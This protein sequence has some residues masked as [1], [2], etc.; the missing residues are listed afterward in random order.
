MVIAGALSL[1]VGPGAGAAVAPGQGTS[2][3]Q[4]LQVTPHE[5]SLAVGVVLGE[6]LAG[7]TN[8]VARAQSQGIDL[9]AIGTSLTGFNCGQSPAVQPSQIPQP[10]QTETGQQ[11]ADQGLTQTPT[12]PGPDLT[13]KNPPPAFGS[14]EF[15]KA[16]A[17]PYGEA[18]TSFAPIDSPV[19]SV[20]GLKTKSW[21]GLIGGQREAGATS[22]VGALSLLGGLVELKGLHWES[23]YPSGG[24]AQP[25]ASFSIGQ[26]LVKGV[27]V[28]V[29]GGPAAVVSAVNKVLGNLGMELVLP[30]K[31]ASS[32]VVSES[33]LQLLVV[34]NDA[35]DNVVNQL[36]NGAAPVLNPLFTG[37]EGGFTPSEPTQLVQLL[38]QSDTPITVADITLAS[39]DGGGFFTA[40]LGGVHAFSGTLAANQFN[41]N[42]PKFGLTG[43][44]T[45]L[46]GGTQSVPGTPGTPGTPAVGATSGLSQP[47]AGSQPALSGAA[48]PSTGAIPQ[49][50]ATAPTARVQTAAAIGHVAGGPL[51]GIGL[52][53][54]GLL[55]LLA[56]GDRRMMRRAQHTVNF[57]E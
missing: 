14:T 32:G 42:L 19:F 7:H 17:A 6:A 1:T 28:P 31:T 12:A 56:E 50:A 10:F 37:L 29:P 30:S 9:G 18:D 41:L 24:S 44:S 23:V 46:I 48:Q 38:C 52:G 26:L 40:A 13:N 34:K 27:A 53:G 57:E 47:V 15:V 54:L 22:D 39:I 2:Y 4:A 55:L 33:P 35:R 45:Q 51:L 20:S 36:L 49:P 5:G 43:G 3:A 11:G 8:F 21:S 25:N 16:T